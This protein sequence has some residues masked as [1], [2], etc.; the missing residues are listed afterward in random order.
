VTPII[1]EFHRDSG[2]IYEQAVIQPVLAHGSELVLSLRRN[3]L[4]A[5]RRD[6][7]STPSGRIGPPRTKGNKKRDEACSTPAPGGDPLTPAEGGW[8]TP[9]FAFLRFFRLMGGLDSGLPSTVL[10]LLSPWPRC[11]PWFSGLPSAIGLFLAFF[12][13][14]REALSGPPGSARAKAHPTSYTIAGDTFVQQF[15]R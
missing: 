13:S 7:N 1:W 3:S 2:A 9:F 5:C 15:K 11:A 4:W 8:P 10:P 6:G 12:A 14:W